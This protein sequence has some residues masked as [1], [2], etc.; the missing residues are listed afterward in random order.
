MVKRE[1][2][3]YKALYFDLIVKRLKKYHSETSPRGGYGKIR[4]LFDR[5]IQIWEYEHIPI[6][7][8]RV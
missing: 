7:R 8:D 2:R 4:D 1:I 6:G 5:K 3:H